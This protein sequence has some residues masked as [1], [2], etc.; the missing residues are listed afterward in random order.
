LEN[1]ALILSVFRNTLIFIY[2]HTHT[3]IDSVAVGAVDLSL[4]FCLPEL[5]KFLR[6][7][8]AI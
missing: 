6:E 8:K 3:I 1:I 4:G 5:K 7:E 2:I